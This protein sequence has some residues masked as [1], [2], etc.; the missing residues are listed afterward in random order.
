MVTMQ[1]GMDMIKL[2]FFPGL[3]FLAACGVLLLF[4]EGWLQVA[5]LGGRGPRPRDL[6]AAGE[7]LHRALIDQALRP[8]LGR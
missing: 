8:H 3:L 1:L 7:D 6:A 4:L 5:F 2:L